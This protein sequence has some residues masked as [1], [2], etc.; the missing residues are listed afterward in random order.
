L[1]RREDALSDQLSAISD[2]LKQASDVN[3]KKRLEAESEKLTAERC[4]LTASI[5]VPPKYTSADFISTGGAR[6]WS[7][8]G[9]LDVPK[10]RWISFP[11]CEGPDGT[12]VICW[13]GYDHLQQAQAISAHYV[14]VQTEFGGSDDP[15]L[16]PLLAS[17]IEL[18]P[19]LKQWHNEPNANFDGLRMGDYFEGFVNEEA[20]NLGKT[21]AEI[22]AWVPPKK[23]AKAK[24][25]KR[26]PKKA[27]S[28]EG[29]E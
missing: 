4:S 28:K 18:L 3:E 25:P 20:R 8:R 15:R 6:Y 27:K 19:W 2:Q 13:A 21:V 1:Q 9:K 24:A 29:A 14:R 7:L 17:L 10:E 12:L 11:H 26:S 22:K 16:I 5:S 23:V